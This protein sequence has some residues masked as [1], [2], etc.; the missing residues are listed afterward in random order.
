MKHA[1]QNTWASGHVVLLVCIV[2]I[3]GGCITV[4]VD[5]TPTGGGPA[6]TCYKSD[7]TGYTIPSGT[8]YYDCST[9]PCQP[10]T[11]DGT[12]TCSSGMKCGGGTGM[13]NKDKT[14][15]GGGGT[16]RQTY[17]AGIC[18]CKCL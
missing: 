16:C 3:L 1:I 5:C 9:S 13:G 4:N 14:C 15:V 8:T 17:T 18:D 11:A 6:G 12:Q 2:L 10:M 7:A